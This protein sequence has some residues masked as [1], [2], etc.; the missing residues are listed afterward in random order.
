MLPRNETLNISIVKTVLEQFVRRTHITRFDSTTLWSERKEMI[1]G[2]CR[3]RY[4]IV[5]FFTAF[6][7]HCPFTVGCSSCCRSVLN[8]TSFGPAAAVSCRQ[9]VCTREEILDR[10]DG[11]RIV[12]ERVVQSASGHGTGRIKLDRVYL[13]YSQFK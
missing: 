8:W 2:C 11:H 4:G 7:K 3:G 9:D 5:S 10:R 12:A 1:Y 6:A 13:A